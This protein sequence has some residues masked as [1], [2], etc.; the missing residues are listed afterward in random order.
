MAT[1]ICT[2][3]LTN[4]IIEKNIP[5]DVFI[6]NDSKFKSWS[7]TISLDTHINIDIN[8]TYEIILDDGRS[9]SILFIKEKASSAGKRT[10]EFKGTG[11]LN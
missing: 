10:I 8:Q 11:A 3:K 5:I 2:I 9:G 1:F 7:G 6:N 4:K